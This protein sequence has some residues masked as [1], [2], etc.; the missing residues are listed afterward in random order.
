MVLLALC[1]WQFLREIHR[2]WTT[3][4]ATVQLH[5]WFYIVLVMLHGKKDMF[6]NIRCHLVGL[7][8]QSVLKPIVFVFFH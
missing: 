8:T 6:C 3:V 5:I 2:N 4:S 1:D 7:N